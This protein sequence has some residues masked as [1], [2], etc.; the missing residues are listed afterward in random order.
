MREI[1][2]ESLYRDI[3]YLLSHVCWKLLAYF[4]E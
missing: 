2:E 4:D 1:K 3:D